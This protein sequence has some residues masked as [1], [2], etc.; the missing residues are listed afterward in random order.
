MADNELR[1]ATEAVDADMADTDLLPITK[2]AAGSGLF[3]VKL[4]TLKAY[5]LTSIF[6]A[7]AG[8]DGKFL[9]VNAGANAVEWAVPDGGGGGTP[10]TAHRYWRVL[11]S[12]GRGFYAY[13]VAEMAFRATPG[14]AQL[15]ADGTPITSETPVP[16]NVA[17]KAFDGDLT[18]FWSGDFGANTQFA[19]RAYWLGYQFANPVTVQEVAL[20]A[21]NPTTDGGK[22]VP[23]LGSVQ[24][25]DDG[26]TWTTRW[27]YDVAVPADNSVLTLTDPA[28]ETGSG[29]GG[30]GVAVP[31]IVQKA[32]A[33]GT[34]GST[35]S[36]TL[37]AAPTIGNTLI[38]MHM[39]AQN[40]VSAVSG[41][42]PFGYSNSNTQAYQNALAAIRYVQAND[43][44]SFTFDASDVW[45]M[46]IYEI[47][48]I[49]SY[50][51]AQFG[52]PL[53]NNNSLLEP[54]LRPPFGKGLRFIFQEQDNS[55]DMT[56][57]AITGLS[58]EHQ[59]TDPGTLNHRALLGLLTPDFK[60]NISSTVTGSLSYPIFMLCSVGVDA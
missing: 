44:L 26:L 40:S 16:A 22:Q 39:G 14:G 24:Y 11:M 13:C 28:P 17:S 7:F 50:A 32:F 51:N 23:S 56:F 49:V 21:R 36:I 4:S 43:P 52:I 47:A 48:G 58:T 27:S 8:N 3:R 25:S 6:P 12:A 54:A 37:P 55:G 31:A 38:I 2:A 9:R 41:F 19:P 42:A 18:S 15:A 29:D 45:N 10:I 35:Q 34:Q 5:F 60:G 30:G 57:D 59:Y 53:Q 1:T 46:A 20:S 33:R